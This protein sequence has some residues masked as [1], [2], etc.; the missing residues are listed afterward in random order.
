MSWRAQDIARG[1]G[2][3]IARRALTSARSCIKNGSLLQS[4]YLFF[5]VKKEISILKR[6]ELLTAVGLL[7]L[8]LI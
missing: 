1:G 7:Q 2:G 8:S 5:A 6:S 4:V 3:R